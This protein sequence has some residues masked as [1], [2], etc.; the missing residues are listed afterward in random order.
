MFN[1]YQKLALHMLKS[2]GVKNPIRRYF[3]DTVCP[4]CVLQFRSR[5]RIFNHLQYRSRVCRI[6]LMLSNPII[7]Q[8]TANV[9]DFKQREFAKVQARK[10]YRNHKA[11]L[12]TFRMPGPLPFVDLFQMPGIATPSLHHML[13]PGRNYHAL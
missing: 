6:Y 8:E 1:T 3:D 5:I 7:S 4:V 11:H 10:G 13:G 12:L 9:L 2:H